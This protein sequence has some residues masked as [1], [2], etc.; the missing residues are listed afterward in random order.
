MPLQIETKILFIALLVGLA[1]IA[2]GIA[3]LVTPDALRV[4]PLELLTLA[5]D[6]LGYT[7]GGFAG[8]LLVAAGV[9]AVIGASRGIAA[10]RALR[11]LLFAPQQVL[12][13]LQLASISIALILG[14]YPDGYTPQGGAWFI[15]ADQSWAWILAVSHSVF[16]GAFIY[17][18]T[19][20][21]RSG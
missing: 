12:L 21:G 2:S 18:G 10:T 13:L 1:H 8:A 16:L 4:T 7:R 6:H 15:L 14:H 19:R 20:N 3:V 9:M 5:S 11:C 17:G